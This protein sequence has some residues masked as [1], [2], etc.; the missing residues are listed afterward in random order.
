MSI[1][2]QSPRLEI[3]PSNRE[4]R[5][6]ARSLVRAANAYGRND[7]TRFAKIN[8][9][10]DSKTSTSSSL[11]NRVRRMVALHR[12][13]EKTRSNIHLHKALGSLFEKDRGVVELASTHFSYQIKDIIDK[14]TSKEGESRALQKAAFKPLAE[15]MNKAAELR[16]TTDKL[17]NLLVAE[18]EYLE[19]ATKVKLA[20]R[21]VRSLQGLT[22]LGVLGLATSFIIPNQNV[23]IMTGFFSFMAIIAGGVT[24]ILY[25]GRKLATNEFRNNAIIPAIA[26]MDK[27]KGSGLA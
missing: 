10:P 2:A 3:N 14:N 15:S 19:K 12:E 17:I 25:P 26:A 9:P 21:V 8:M 13:N 4:V 5:K 11:R 23:A 18:P 16:T 20:N 6:V 1:Y 22:S 7:L 27:N 24:S